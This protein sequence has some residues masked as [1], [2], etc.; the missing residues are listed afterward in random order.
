VHAVMNVFQ[1]LSFRMFAQAS[2]RK[3]H[4]SVR[5]GESRFLTAALRRFGMTEGWVGTTAVACFV[6]VVSTMSAARG[7]SVW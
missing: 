2:M 3:L 6:S 7:W 4:C 1:S 5:D